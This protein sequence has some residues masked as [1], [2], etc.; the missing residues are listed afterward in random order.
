MT[1]NNSSD[2]DRI[3]MYIITC[4]I[5]IVLTLIILVFDMYEVLNVRM[6]TL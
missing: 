6:I 4:V 2:H 5:M 1:N 3:A